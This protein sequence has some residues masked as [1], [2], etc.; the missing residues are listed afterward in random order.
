MDESFKVQ[1]LASLN[2]VNRKFSKLQTVATTFNLLI[3]LLGFVCV[4]A[5]YVISNIPRE[6]L[7]EILGGT[8]SISIERPAPP[9]SLKKT[10]TAF[11]KTF[12]GLLG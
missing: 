6:Q 12:I 3:L 1:Y 2:N 10:M 9:P 11:S 5:G 8:P 4:A 7:V